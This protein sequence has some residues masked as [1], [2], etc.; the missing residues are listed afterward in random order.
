MYGSTLKKHRLHHIS[1]SLNH[2]DIDR[3]TFSFGPNL[4]SPIKGT[5]KLEPELTKTMAK[6]P[7]TTFIFKTYKKHQKGYQWLNAIECH[8]GTKI[9]TIQANNVDS[10][11]KEELLLQKEERIVSVQVETYSSWTPV[12]VN[13]LILS[14]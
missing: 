11:E 14:E 12:K 4:Q 3:L 6:T 8:F 7:P 1:Y 13:F 2:C 10:V 5:Y 9:L